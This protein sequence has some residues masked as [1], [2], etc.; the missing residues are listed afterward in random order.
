MK[1]DPR[2]GLTLTYET[3]LFELWK[4]KSK[5]GS[6]HSATPLRPFI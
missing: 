3:G 4:D 6:D 1:T 5:C 2:N